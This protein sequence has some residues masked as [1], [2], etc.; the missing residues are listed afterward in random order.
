MDKRVLFFASVVAM[1]VGVCQP[2]Q[3][4]NAGLLLSPTRLVIEN[5]QRFATVTLRN[6]G[7]GVGRYVIEM[8]DAAMSETGAIKILDLGVHQPNSALDIVSL[9]PHGVTL[10][11][12]DYQTIRILLKNTSD[13]ADG[14]Y[15]SHLQV[16]M[17][18]ADIENA[19]V[20]P[21]PQQTVVAPR[22]LLTTVIPIIFHK[23]TTHF[24]LAIEGAKLT[25]GPEHQPQL[26]LN[27]AFSGNCSVIGDVKVSHTAP[28]GM[29]SDIGLFRGVAIYRDVS[30]RSQ[31]VPLQVP[32]GVNL[33]QGTISVAFLSQD[34]S[35]AKVLAQ[36]TIKAD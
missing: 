2:V 19:D 8:V 21:D 27:I 17:T 9:S 20:K 5:G 34:K 28:N 12:D 10:K 26:N 33:R 4:R 31:I 1:V 13:L 14:E 29:V 30:K 35:G 3:A 15:R 22:A 11:P 24:E 18:Q 25:Q 23:G 7:D 36:K 6:N 32:K 16:R